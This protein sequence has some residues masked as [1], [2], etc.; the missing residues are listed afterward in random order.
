MN[1]EFLCPANVDCRVLRGCVRWGRISFGPCVS[2]HPPRPTDRPRLEVD[3]W[4]VKKGTTVATSESATEDRDPFVTFMVSDLYDRRGHKC[5][6][7]YVPLMSHDRSLC[8]DPSTHHV[9]AVM[10]YLRT[11][12]LCR[13]PW[14]LGRWSGRDGRGVQNDRERK[15]SCEKRSEQKKDVWTETLSLYVSTTFV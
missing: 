9:R 10:V 1:P 4:K 15:S 5:V 7:W 13:Q 2:P 3:D 11:V 14:V 8:K 6:K 12:D